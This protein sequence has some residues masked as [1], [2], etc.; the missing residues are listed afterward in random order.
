MKRCCRAG[1]RTLDSGRALMA[2]GFKTVIHVDEGFEGDLDVNEHRS[3]ING[4]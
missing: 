3:T 1:R 4:W 2:A